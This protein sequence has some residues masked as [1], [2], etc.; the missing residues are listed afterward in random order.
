MAARP[1]ALVDEDPADAIARVME[2]RRPVLLRVYAHRL[3]RADLEDCLQ[4]AAL[5]LI[6]RAR[7][8][9]GAFADDAHVANALA[10]RFLSRVADRH[11]ALGG[12]S[13]AR[14]AARRPG[15]TAPGRRLPVSRR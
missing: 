12:R 14:S 1:R 11:R 15:R 9:D 10:Q 7:G 6:P 5:E 2:A 3:P 4:Q 13:P 8:R